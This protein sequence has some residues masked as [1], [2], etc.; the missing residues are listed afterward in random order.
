MFLK[1]RNMQISAAMVKQLREKTSAGVMDCRNALDKCQG[2]M[3]KAAEI[4]R[5]KGL[6]RVEKRAGR[7]ASD[8]VIET[9]THGKRIGAMVE[10]NCETDFVAKTPD[11][12]ELAHDLVLQVAAT[13]PQYVSAED[14]PEG[15][16][17]DPAQDCLLE[18]KFI[19][20]ESKTI[21]DLV[22]DVAAK[23]GEKILV[24]RFARFELG[25]RSED[26]E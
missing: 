12:K 5:E 24:G 1:G 21:A 16:T 9:Y 25:K 8:G 10:L 15:A 22:N 19:K 20:D 3:E 7:E 6:A 14:I 18:Q 11:F 4:L 17:V 13:D 23:M 26:E 2:D